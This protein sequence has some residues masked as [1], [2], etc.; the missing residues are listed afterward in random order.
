M[1]T[2]DDEDSPTEEHRTSTIDDTDEPLLSL[3]D[4]SVEFKEEP[5]IE[6]ALPDRLVEYWGLGEEP[7]QAVDGISLE[8]EEDD[9]VVLVGESG[10]GKTT[11]GRT[12]IGLQERTDGA[13]KYRGY[14]IKA[15]EEGEYVG[16]IFFEDIRRK[17]QII[18]QDSNAALNP[19]RTVRATLSEPL[20]LWYPELDINDRY[21]RILKMLETTGVTPAEEYMERYPHQLSGG[22]KQR[23]AIIRAMLVEPDVILADEVVSALDVSLRIS[24]MDLLLELQDMFGTSYLFISHNLSN[25]KY[26]ASKGEGRI[27]V[28][29]LGR[30]VE[31]GPAEEV[32]ENPKHPYTKILKWASLP[33][34]PDEARETITKESPMMTTTAPDPSDPPS[35]CRFHK[36]CPYARETCQEVD[37]ELGVGSSED[38]PHRAACFRQDDDHEYWQSEPIHE[39]EREIPE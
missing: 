28:M 18:H 11:F 19:Y 12:A 30:I 39:E 37:P 13:V 2:T 8:L 14:D 27:A 7:V 4:V 15:V 24:I 25:A 20:K 36:A 17:L 32:I 16:E 35:G 5:L 3:E 21:E 22:E 10:S 29:Y 26:F 23:I 34:D 38:A 1:S 9:T 31:I 33:I 6:Q